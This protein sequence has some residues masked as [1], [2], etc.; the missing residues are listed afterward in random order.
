MHQFKPCKECDGEAMY[1]H[2]PAVGNLPAEHQ[3]VC[4]DCTYET[5]IYEYSLH[6]VKEWNRKKRK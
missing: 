5:E 6:V 1:I 3:A 2:L 4:K